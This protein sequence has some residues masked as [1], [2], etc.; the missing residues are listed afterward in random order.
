MSQRDNKHGKI[1]K[2]NTLQKDRSQVNIMHASI[3]K[4]KRVQIEEMLLKR[5]YKNKTAYLCPK[6]KTKLNTKDKRWT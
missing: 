2:N 1:K 3:F 6:C 5:N 4:A